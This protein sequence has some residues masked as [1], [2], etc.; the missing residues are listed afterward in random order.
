MAILS[1]YNIVFNDLAWFDTDIWCGCC[2]STKSWFLY[3]GFI[4]ETSDCVLDFAVL[5]YWLKCL[6]WTSGH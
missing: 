3:T 4:S 6:I 5:V 2:P 1:Y